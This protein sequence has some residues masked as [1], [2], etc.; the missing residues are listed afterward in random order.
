MIGPASPTIASQRP[1]GATRGSALRRKK[2]AVQS[3]VLKRGARIAAERVEVEDGRKSNR[4]ELCK[5]LETCGVTGAALLIASFDRLA[6]NVAF[7]AMLI[8]SGADFVAVDFPLAN[9][10]EKQV[11]AG[12][13]KTKCGLC[14]KRRHAGSRLQVLQKS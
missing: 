9:S 3:F 4:S 1:G 10:F 6:R 12:P 2:S 14:S 8:E 13:W 11:L 7:M 5:A